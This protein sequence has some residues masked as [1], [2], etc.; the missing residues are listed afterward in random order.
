MSQVRLERGFLACAPPISS[1]AVVLLLRVC[2]A[3]LCPPIVRTVLEGD[4]MLCVVMQFLPSRQKA[5]VCPRVSKGWLRCA[6]SPASW[7]GVG[8]MD[9]TGKEDLQIL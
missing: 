1:H 5:A 6:K 4:D 2:A 3:E 9:K 8:G 7:R